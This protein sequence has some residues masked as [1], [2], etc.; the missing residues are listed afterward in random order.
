M[1]WAIATDGDIWWEVISTAADGQLTPLQAELPHESTFLLRQPM[2]FVYH[3]C[4]C[5]HR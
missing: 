5:G 4:Q 2:R 1:G 3:F